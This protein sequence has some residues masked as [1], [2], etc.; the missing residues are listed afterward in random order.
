MYIYIYK[1]THICISVYHMYIIYNYCIGLCHPSRSWLIEC[2]SRERI[3]TIVCSM[4]SEETRSPAGSPSSLPPLLAAGFLLP[5]SSLFFPL[6]LPSTRTI[7]IGSEIT[8]RR[9]HPP[10]KKKKKKGKNW[11]TR[12]PILSSST[13]IIIIIIIIINSL[14]SRVFQV[15]TILTLD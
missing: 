15:L 11:K 12:P 9:L 1:Y 14:G 5:S 7:L 6:P 10:K 8:S 2:L 3:K 13:S 4:T